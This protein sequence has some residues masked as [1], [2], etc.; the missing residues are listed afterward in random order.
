[1]HSAH[2]HATIL[3]M[4][5]QIYTYHLTREQLHLGHI[6]DIPVGHRVLTRE[7]NRMS[8]RSWSVCL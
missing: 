7:N 4:Y 8:P 6:P 3:L 1:M 2:Q 5:G